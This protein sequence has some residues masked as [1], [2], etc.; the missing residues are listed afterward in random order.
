MST[1]EAIRSWVSLGQEWR[2]YRVEGGP[3]PLDRFRC[4][5]TK[6]PQRL[7]GFFCLID[8]FYPE[9]RS[10]VERKADNP[11]DFMDTIALLKR[12]AEQASLVTVLPAG[13]RPATGHSPTEK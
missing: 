1:K 12:E 11:A 2:P 5:S 4:A 7:K 8:G 10:S 6:W 13:N 3:G 9:M